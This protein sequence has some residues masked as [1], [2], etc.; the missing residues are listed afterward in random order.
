MPIINSRLS[1]RN[2]FSLSCTRQYIK[3]P[4]TD[5]DILLFYARLQQENSW[6]KVAWA[7]FALRDLAIEL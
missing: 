5:L 1:Q 3:H 2:M 6:I 4:A 7:N